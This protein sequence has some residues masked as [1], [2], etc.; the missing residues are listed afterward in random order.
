[1]KPDGRVWRVLRMCWPLFGGTWGA[2]LVVRRLLEIRLNPDSFG[3]AAY[4]M[5]GSIFAII[6]FVAGAAIAALLGRLVEWLMRRVGAGVAAAVV[7]ATLANVLAIWQIGAFVQA[8]SPGLRA[9]VAVKPR[10]AKSVDVPPRA[11][12]DS[13]YK[14][15]RDPRPVDAREAAAWDSECH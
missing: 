7:V 13:R 2:W 3:S 4:L 9:P 6:F 1:M 11:S 15:C 12:Q 5:F 10:A 14:T 8:T